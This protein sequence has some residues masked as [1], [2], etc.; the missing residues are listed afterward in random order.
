MPASAPRYHPRLLRAIRR[1]DDE[2]LSIAEVCRRVGAAAEEIGVPRPS[3][4]HVRRIVLS[5]RARAAELRE[6]RNEALVGLV[7]RLFRSRR[8]RTPSARGDRS[9]PAASGPAVA[10]L[11]TVWAEWRRHFVALSHKRTGATYDNALARQSVHTPLNRTVSSRLFQM[12]EIER[13]GAHV[14][15]E[16]GESTATRPMWRTPRAPGLAPERDR[17]EDPQRYRPGIRRRLANHRDCVR[18]A[19]HVAVPRAEPEQRPLSPAD[20]GDRA[21]APP[22]SSGSPLPRGPTRRERMPRRSAGGR[23]PPPVL[24]P[25]SLSMPRSVKL[26]CSGS[27]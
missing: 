26:A 10:G 14:A 21:P 19:Q 16:I 20:R 17:Q 7:A 15:A 18:M 8:P 11:T 6:I 23:G 3:Y 1:L 25:R 27:K 13:G 2:S 4:V 22:R 5:E 24:P 12:L 9:R